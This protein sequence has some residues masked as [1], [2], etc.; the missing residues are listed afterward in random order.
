VNFTFAA[1]S[2]LAGGGTFLNLK[3][4]LASSFPFRSTMILISAHEIIGASKSGAATIQRLIF[5]I[6][7]PVL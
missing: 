6:A 7:S 5:F 4:G 1:A 3:L 2:L